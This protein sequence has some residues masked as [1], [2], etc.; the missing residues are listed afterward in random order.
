M[1]TT[2]HTLIALDPRGRRHSISRGRTV[3]TTALDGSVSPD[4]D[5]GL[6]I[7]ETRML[8]RHRWLVNGR[9]PTFSALS[10]V[11]Q[12][13]DLAYYIFAPSD[14]GGDTP[15]CDPAQ[16][17]VELL[18][19]RAVGEG[20]REEVTIVNHTQMQTTFDFAL[21]LD[22]DF[23]DPAE[24]DGPRRQTGELAVRCDPQCPARFLTFDYRARHRYSHQGDTGV[25]SLRRAIR[26][27]VTHDQEPPA[28]RDGS[29]RFRVHLDPREIWRA[30]LLWTPQLEGRELPFWDGEADRKRDAFRASS[31]HYGSSMDGTE[32]ATVLQ[33]L[34]RATS[35]LAALRLLDLD[36]EDALGPTWI[37]AAGIP[38]YLGLFGRDIL[39][40]ARQAASLNAVSMRGALST[41][42][43]H[44]GTKVDDWRDEQ[45]GRMVH[46]MHTNPLS[47]LEYDP[48]G[49]YFGT[50]SGS[51]FFPSLVA[52][53]WRWTGDGALIRPLIEPALRGLRWADSSSRDESGFYRYRTRSEQGEKN[54]GWKDSDDAIVHAD[55]SQ[56]S[57]PLGTCEMQAYAYGSKVGLGEV[58]AAL[59]EK[60]AAARLTAEAAELKGRFND[61]FWMEDEGCLAMGIDAL[62]QP[63]RSIASDPAHCL[64]NGIVDDALR[65]KVAARLMKDD[66]F[67]G[68]GLRTLSSAHPAYNPF[69]YHRGSVWPVEGAMFVMALARCGL[70]DDMNRLA[71]AIFEASALFQFHRLPEVFGGHQRDEE[72]PF[73]GLYPKANSPQ[74]WSASAPFLMMQAILG[75]RPD[76]PHEHLT[77]DPHLPDWL[78][79]I[80]IGRLRVGKAVVDIAFERDADGK[81]SFEVLRLDGTLSVV[82]AK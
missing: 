13:R 1:T 35:D 41:L 32:T 76:A 67:S 33:A 15:S 54:Q 28:Y 34:S 43:Q 42:A 70:D 46:E 27:G 4:G 26:L 64:L 75:I 16:Q 10:A 63:I 66:M 12:H 29:L 61:L 48:H 36:G 44:L 62:G 23:A 18:I 17:S 57:A 37:P 22:S 77:V 81:T 25:A 60:E 19:A 58:L 45:P 50:V 73:P 78:P 20:L 69:S 3:L 80:R 31:A 55:G 56:V 59:G 11:E 24:V 72:H 68:W 7:Y 65:N 51:L 6:W 74:A 53:L 8:S 39:F 14:C 2:D 49:R 21:E 5:Q 79:E 47:V 71:K 82:R 30:T 52:E 9:A 38:M 40:S